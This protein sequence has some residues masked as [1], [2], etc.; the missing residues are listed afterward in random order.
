MIYRGYEAVIGLEVHVELD[1]AS[2][3]FCACSTRFGAEPNTQICPVCTGQPGALPTVNRRAV[4]LT[5]KA[6]LATHCTVAERSSFDRKNYFYPDLP[7][8]YQITAKHSAAIPHM[9]LRRYG[10]MGVYSASIMYC[11]DCMLETDG[12]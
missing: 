6:G 12:R 10:F 7:K 3:V 1:T 9:R 8:G 4:E 11:W 5:V 2:K